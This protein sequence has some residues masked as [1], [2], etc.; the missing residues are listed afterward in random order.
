MTPRSTGL[1]QQSK[2]KSGRTPT[3]SRRAFLCAK[4]TRCDGPHAGLLAAAGNGVAHHCSP[5]H[6]FLLQSKQAMF[7]PSARVDFELFIDDDDE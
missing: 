2:C 4:S 7:Y 3:F 1:T 6:I 5:C